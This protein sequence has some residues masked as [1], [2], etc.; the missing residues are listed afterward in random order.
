MGKPKISWHSNPNV[1]ES[2]RDE[3]A[4]ESFLKFNPN[5]L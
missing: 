4:R 2:I 3:K 5:Y 1:R